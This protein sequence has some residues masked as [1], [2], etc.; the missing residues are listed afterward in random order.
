MHKN[1]IVLALLAAAC[2]GAQAQQVWRCGNGYGTQPCAGGTT[3]A[4]T[5]GGD[6]N[7]AARA[8]AA[9]KV[10]A[11]RAHALEQARLAREK[12]APKAIV[13][14]PPPAAVDA[15]E[16]VKARKTAEGKGKLG[17][18]TATAPGKP[19]ADKKKKKAKPSG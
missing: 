10:D 3:V 1:T 19:A 15:A 7:A 18:F 5:P 12:Q 17:S 14:A 8:V 11:Q 13:M 9:A 6:D 2:A 16:K 4:T